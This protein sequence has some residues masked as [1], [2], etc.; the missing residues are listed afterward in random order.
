MRRVFEKYL[1]PGFVFQSAIVAGAYGSGAEFREFF[2]P[3]GPVGGLLAI[4][5][6]MVT[7]SIIAMVGLEFARTFRVYEYRSFMRGLLGRGWVLFEILYILLMLLVLSVIGAAAGV[8]TEDIL[9][10]D[11]R[12]GTLVMM[13]TIGV[14]VFFG[15]TVIERVLSLWSVVLYG[16]YV[17]FFIAH[18]EQFGSEISTA[19]A[20]DTVTSDWYVGG[21]RYSGLIIPVIAIMAFVARHLETRS[22]AIVAGAL[23]GPLIMIPAFLFYLA[24]V[25]HFDLIDSS[26]PNAIPLTVLLKVLEGG[27]VF[28]ILFPVVL[29]G[30]F[31]ETGA[32]FIHAMNERIAGTYEEQG[33]SMPSWTRP[34]VAMVAL[35]LTFFI[36][37]KVG[38]TALIG[39]GYGTITYAFMLVF[40]VPLLTV[41]V[42]KVLRGSPGLLAPGL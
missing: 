38:L 41:G 29:F 13:V 27:E 3:F 23:S 40:G 32:A 15:T 28:A 30:T 12:W 10:L 9:G 20:S 39:Q 33:K 18:F 22:D 36:A 26:R 2:M 6:V 35:V 1:L 21:L 8:V 4:V 25:G 7:L 17:A 19:L 42:W 37:D 34:A 16:V 14:L 11:G 31:I 5:V 24:I